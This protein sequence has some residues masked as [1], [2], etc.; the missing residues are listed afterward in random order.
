M[1]HINKSILTMAATTLLAGGLL[2]AQGPG[3]GEHGGPGGHMKM[4]ATALGLTDAQ[5]AQMKTIMEAAKT[6][7]QPL[8]ATLQQQEQAVEAAIKAGKSADEV[9]QLAALEG[10]AMGQLAAIHASSQAQVFAIL[11]PDQ[12]TK[13]AA[14]HS[15]M[16]GHGRG[17]PGG[18]GPQ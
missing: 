2:F 14:M 10:P 12:Q 13:M 15:M 3:P 8:H 16:G 4:M 18:P 7:S 17:G 6:A 9:S 5:Q 1:L 11:T